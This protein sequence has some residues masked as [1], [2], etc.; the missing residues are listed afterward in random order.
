MDHIIA[1]F[2]IR[3]FYHDNRDKKLRS[4]ITFLP[5]PP[6]ILFNRQENLF[7]SIAPAV[8]HNILIQDTL[9]PCALCHSPP[10]AHTIYFPFSATAFVSSMSI[11]SWKMN[12]WVS[13]R[14]WPQGP[15]P[16]PSGYH[17]Q[18]GTQHNHVDCC[19]WS[20]C[21]PGHFLVKLLV[22]SLKYADYFCS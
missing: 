8:A 14:Y 3:H 6:C 12:K 5:S 21:W 16:K 19:N 22:E 9:L 2:A 13:V 4:R 11:T 10:E 17:Y 20:P 15:L 7:Y 18:C 1:Q